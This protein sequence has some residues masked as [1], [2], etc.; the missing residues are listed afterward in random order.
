MVKLLPIRPIMNGDYMSPIDTFRT[1]NIFINIVFDQNED[2]D[3]LKGITTD[4]WMPEPPNTVNEMPPVYLVD[5]MDS[6][7]GPNNIH[8]SFTTRWAE[9]SFNQL[10]VLGDFVNVNIAQSRITPNNPDATFGT[11]R[12]VDSVSSLINDNGGLT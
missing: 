10:I 4:L 3:S 11:N 9:A 6:D 2:S 7:F 1:L 12:L 5:F 8:G